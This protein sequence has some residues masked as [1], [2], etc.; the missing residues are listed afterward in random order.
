MTLLARSNAAWVTIYDVV[1][2]VGPP[3]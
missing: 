1:P 3:R 2:C